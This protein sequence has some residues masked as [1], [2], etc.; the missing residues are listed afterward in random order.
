MLLPI[1][2]SFIKEVNNLAGDPNS[3]SFDEELSSC[4]VIM[5]NE[6]NPVN[7]GCKFFMLNISL[8]ILRKI[9][10]YLTI[11]K[12][13]SDSLLSHDGEPI[14]QTVL[15]L[16]LKGIVYAIGREEEP[17]DENWRTTYRENLNQPMAM[18]I[19]S[20][21]ENHRME[22][23]RP[24]DSSLP[25][26]LTTPSS[27]IVPTSGR[28]VRQST[29]ARSSKNSTE[30]PPK[31]M[32]GPKPGTSKQSTYRQSSNRSES[33]ASDEST[34]GKQSARGLFTPTRG[35]GYHHLTTGRRGRTSSISSTS[36]VSPLSILA[37]SPTPESRPPETSQR[38]SPSSSSSTNLPIRLPVIQKHEPM[39]VNPEPS[40]SHIATS[41]SPLSTHSSISALAS[42]STSTSAPPPAPSVPTFGLIV[43]FGGS[44]SMP[45]YD[46][47]I[48]VLDPYRDRIDTSPICADHV[49]IKLKCK[50]DIY[51][52]KR[53]IEILTRIMPRIVVTKFSR[54]ALDVPKQLAPTIKEFVN[55]NV[56]ILISEYY[57]YSRPSITDENLTTIEI[58]ANAE[59]QQSIENSSRLLKIGEQTGRA[60]PIRCYQECSRCFFCYDD[61]HTECSQMSLMEMEGFI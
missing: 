56:T 42:S 30:S 20:G 52:L 3:P 60:I 47:L 22:H 25:I 9:L 34:P 49:F 8:T 48:Q 26:K 35:T 24:N 51:F 27:T 58:L 32:T 43:S 14:N 45:I 55:L 41:F 44:V 17:I 15:T 54:F 16:A 18:E 46:E 4:L 7:L 37:P 6:T 13:R 1:I 5:A 12:L 28:S 33:G 21:D 2:D 39:V 23:I 57:V 19:S 59:C 29:S 36:S 10:T 38:S 61:A 40:T 31:T 11:L 53:Q 50:K